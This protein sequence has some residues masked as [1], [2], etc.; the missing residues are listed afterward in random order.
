MQLE[1]VVTDIL[2]RDVPDEVLAAI[3]AKAKRVGLTRNE[4]LR[5]TLERE[6]FAAARPVS[7]EDLQQFAALVQDLEDPAVMTGA[8]S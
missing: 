2:I 1:V 4:Y 5:R 7:V 6:S 8:W 3:D